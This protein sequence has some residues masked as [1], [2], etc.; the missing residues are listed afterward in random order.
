MSTS[1][2]LICRGCKAVLPS[3][4]MRAAERQAEEAAFKAHRDADAAVE[5]ATTAK[6]AAD[7]NL[8]SAI[9]VLKAAETSLESAVALHSKSLAERDVVEGTIA[10]LDAK[11]HGATAA[12]ASAE[13]A[14]REALALVRTTAGENTS[15]VPA[16]DLSAKLSDAH[17]LVRRLELQKAACRHDLQ[18]KVNAL[19][20]A[21]QSLSLAQASHATATDAKIAAEIV[22][23]EMAAQL[24]RAVDVIAKRQ[25]EENQDIAAKRATIDRSFRVYCTTCHRTTVFPFVEEAANGFNVDPAF[26]R[27]KF[28]LHQK[29]FSINTRYAVFDEAGNEIMHVMRPTY[30]LQNLLAAFAIIVEIIVLMGVSLF[31]GL[32]LSNKIG[33]GA[34]GI[35]ILL[36]VI[37]AGAAALYTY[38]LLAPKRHITFYRDAHYREVVLQVRQDQKVTLRM[39]RYTVLD[40]NG[41]VVGS[42]RKDYLAN[43]LRTKWDG[44]DSDGNHLYVI[45]EDELIMAL[46]RRFVGSIIAMLPTN[47]VIHQVNGQGQ[48]GPLLGEFIRKF[49]LLDRYVLDCSHDRDRVMDRRMAIAIGVLLD[50]GESR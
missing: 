11:L 13:T 47:F 27:D 41:V 42:F 5:A 16:D 33:D 31:A 7:E 32:S 29:H 2:Q 9:A 50:T 18:A 26:A 17:D 24:S 25:A 49:T 43:F 37:I 28:L 14:I 48:D 34:T 1:Q 46:L 8:I 12:T 45:R 44:F 10:E 4:E 30:L 15:S 35:V 40:P 38:F 19:D 23:S 21:A 36:G 20:S 39:M 6:S 22:A 3:E